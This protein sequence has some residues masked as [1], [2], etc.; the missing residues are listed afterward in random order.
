MVQEK[1]RKPNV[2]WDFIKKILSSDPRYYLVKFHERTEIFDTFLKSLRENDRLK[3]IQK[4]K[5]R[6]VNQKE[7]KSRTQAKDKELEHKE[8]KRRQEQ[9]AENAEPVMVDMELEETED[10]DDSVMEVEITEGIKKLHE[11]FDLE[12]DESP[13]EELNLEHDKE[14]DV[15]KK[16]KKHGDGET[17]EVSNSNKKV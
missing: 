16:V 7:S 3:S 2:T 13:K 6:S 12:L 17:F 4:E 8:L 5:T 15:R 10:M 9:D 11:N 1:V 14:A